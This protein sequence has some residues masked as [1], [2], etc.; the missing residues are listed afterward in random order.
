MKRVLCILIVLAT[1][2]LTAQTAQAA[3]GRVF[4][5]PLSTDG[6][7][8]LYFGF[9]FGHQR[10]DGDGIRFL[11]NP[12]SGARLQEIPQQSRPATDRLLLRRERSQLG[13]LLLGAKVLQEIWRAS[14][15]SWG[16]TLTACSTRFCFKATLFQRIAVPVGILDRHTRYPRSHPC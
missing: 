1:L 15:L 5:R 8:G 10:D 14:R 13:P 3:G 2:G 16:K 4:I 11:L 6:Q 7:R 12:S 9:S